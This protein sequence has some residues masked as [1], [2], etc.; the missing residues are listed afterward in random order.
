MLK[1]AEKRRCQLLYA[2]RS[3]S[4]NSVT[5]ASTPPRSDDGLAPHSFSHVSSH[6]PVWITAGR[7]IGHLVNFSVPRI[8]QSAHMGAEPFSYLVAF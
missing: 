3:C 2:V 7:S 4:G 5:R 1:G 6:C 8:C